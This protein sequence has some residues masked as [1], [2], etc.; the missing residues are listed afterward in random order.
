MN[1]GQEIQLL[2]DMHGCVS[3][4]KRLICKGTILH[5]YFSQLTWDY[6]KDSVFIL[7]ILF[8]SCQSVR[9][10][11]RSGCYASKRLSGYSAGG[12]QYRTPRK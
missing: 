1:I 6:F 9:H 7:A 2:E 4:G 3:E 11:E 5:Y 10:Q 12:Y 8:T